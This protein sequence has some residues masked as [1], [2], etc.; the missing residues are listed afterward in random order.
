MPRHCIA[1]NRLGST[2]LG[3]VAVCAAGALAVGAFAAGGAFGAAAKAEAAT[4][5]R[6]VATSRRDVE[7]ITSPQDRMAVMLQTAA[8]TGTSKFC[9]QSAR[10]RPQL[11]A[12]KSPLS[13]SGRSRPLPLASLTSVGGARATAD[14]ERT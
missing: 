9:G 14:A 11:P 2:E 3:P 5:Q 4:A 8:E 1:L 10:P 13:V 12:G 7:F 6:A